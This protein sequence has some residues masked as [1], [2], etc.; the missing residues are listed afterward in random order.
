MKRNKRLYRRLA[1]ET[2]GLAKICVKC[3]S[4]KN[5]CIQH[6][7]KNT[8]NNWENNLQ[9]LCRSCHNRLHSI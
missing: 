3:Y 2:Y 6:K 7:D 4:T 8:L 1:F 5:I 9:I